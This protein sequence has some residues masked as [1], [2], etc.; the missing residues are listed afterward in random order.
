MACAPAFTK[1]DLR[2][3]YHQI[4]ISPRDE[5]KNRFPIPR[6]KNLHVTMACA[7]AFTTVDLRSGEDC[8]PKM[9]LDRLK[10]KWVR[11]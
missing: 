11:I 6:L 3:S 8:K 1:V 9:G 4:G 2:S 10:P 7:P 5:W